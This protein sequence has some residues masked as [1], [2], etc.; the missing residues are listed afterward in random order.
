METQTVK[1]PIVQWKDPDTGRIMQG[2]DFTGI[3]FLTWAK[4]ADDGVTMLLAIE[5][6]SAELAKL[7]A[8]AQV[9]FDQIPFLIAQLEET[10]ATK[11]GI[12]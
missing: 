10:A 12:E 11:G 8:D 7:P 9:P 5:A 1:V 3:A 4:I 6:P 2:P